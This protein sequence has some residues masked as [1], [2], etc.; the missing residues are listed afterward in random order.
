MSQRSLTKTGS[1]KMHP[2]SQRYLPCGANIPRNNHSRAVPEQESRPYPPVASLLEKTADEVNAEKRAAAFAKDDERKAREKKG[3]DEQ[4]ARGNREV[5]RRLGAART[6]PTPGRAVPMTP[7]SPGSGSRQDSRS[8]EAE[9]SAP[10]AGRTP[11]A[12]PL[13]PRGGNGS[14]QQN[15]RIAVLKERRELTP[16]RAPPAKPTTPKS[17]SNNNLT[18]VGSPKAR[19]PL[20]SPN[21]QNLQEQGSNLV[22]SGQTKTFAPIGDMTHTYVEYMAPSEDVER[23]NREIAAEKK[24]AEKERLAKEKAEREKAVKESRRQDP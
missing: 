19:Q 5:E 2:L 9:R 8:W 13:S 22:E 7:L 23:M 4:K 15:T 20:P 24:R 3:I 18:P 11:Q 6:A 1:T 10:A 14:G 17:G 16:K 21:E 12:T